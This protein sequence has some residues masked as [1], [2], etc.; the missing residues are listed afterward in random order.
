MAEKK[1]EMLK[2]NSLKMRV[3]NLHELLRVLL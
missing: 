3:K 1:L 2:E